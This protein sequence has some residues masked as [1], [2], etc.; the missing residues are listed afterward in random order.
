[1]ITASGCIFLATTTGRIMLQQRSDSCSYPNT[2]AFFGGKSESNERPIQT[3]LREL[4]EEIGELPKIQKV[5][6]I[7]K[8]TSPDGNFIYNTFLISVLEEFVPT[9]NTESSG[10]CWARLDKFPQPLHPGV[11]AQLRNREIMDKIK[12]IHAFNYTDGSNWL[13]TLTN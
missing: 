4:T 1:M 10:F 7:Y 9:L 3:L 12:T 5:Y 8:F 2:W 6:P 11:K 13:D